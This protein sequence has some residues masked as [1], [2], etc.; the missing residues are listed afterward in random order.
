MGERRELVKCGRFDLELEDH[1]YLVLNGAFY[2]EGGGQGLG[3]GVDAC[4][5][6]AFLKAIGV[7]TLRDV[8]GKSCWVTTPSFGG[9]IEKIEPLHRGDGVPFDIAEWA[10]D[11]EEKRK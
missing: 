7:K 9:N 5:L 8:E 11:L 3:Y 2:T 10:R 1:G 6:K 4:F